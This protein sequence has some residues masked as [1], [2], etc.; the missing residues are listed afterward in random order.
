MKLLGRSGPLP[1]LAGYA[2]IVA[3]LFIL[4]TIASWGDSTDF[5]H[6]NA[7]SGAGDSMVSQYCGAS[8]KSDSPAQQHRK[9]CDSCILCASSGGRYEAPQ[10]IATPSHE[11]PYRTPISSPHL[12]RRL[13]DPPTSDTTGWTSSWSSRAPPLF[14]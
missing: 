5:A 3:V 14:S 10:F 13:V 8:G 4:Q 1:R 9:H 6:Q 11:S 7:G 12:I 2:M